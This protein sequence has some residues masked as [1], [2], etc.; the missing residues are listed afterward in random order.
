MGLSSTPYPKS[1][2]KERQPLS[3]LPPFSVSRNRPQ[4]SSPTMLKHGSPT[5][6]KKVSR[7]PLA[8][9][10]YRHALSVILSTSVD[11]H[12]SYLYRIVSP[13]YIAIPRPSTFFTTNLYPGPHFTYN[14]AP[15]YISTLKSFV[16][17]LWKGVVGMGPIVALHSRFHAASYVSLQRIATSD[18]FY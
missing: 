8:T 13:P 14:T 6:L 1:C 9:Y 17:L 4:P 3:H 10:M 11:S 7:Q 12:P 2:R 5:V 15:I 16:R 18:T